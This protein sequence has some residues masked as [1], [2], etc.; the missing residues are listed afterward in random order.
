MTVLLFEDNRDDEQL[1][2]RALRALRVP[3]LVR[4]ARDGERALRALGLDD[5]K[6]PMADKLPDLVISDFKMPKTNGDEVLRRARADGR[7]DD[8]PFVIFTS[9]DDEADRR[10][11]LESGANEFVTKPVDFGEF[12]SAM[13]RV[14]E[15]WLATRRTPET[16]LSGGTSRE[17]PSSDR[18]RLDG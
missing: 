1:A 13:R 10:R 17:R 15:R 4:V 14:A 2:L 6:S 18:G 16:A 7:L 12:M 8:M 9:S 3:L 5:P 11:C